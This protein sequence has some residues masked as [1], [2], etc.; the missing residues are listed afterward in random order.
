M[1]NSGFRVVTSLIAQD[2]TN[3]S[4]PTNGQLLKYNSTSGKW[5]NAT[6]IPQ[7]SVVNLTT[8]LAAKLAIASNLSD[9]ASAA[10]ARNNLGLGSIATQASSNVTITGGSITG[11]TDL[12]VADGGTGASDASTARTNLGL[13]TIATQAASA[14][15]I[16]GGTLSALTS[17]TGTTIGGTNIVQA[18][19]AG[20]GNQRMAMNASGLAIATTRAIYFDTG[21]ILSGVYD[22]GLIRSATN[23]VKVTDG[24]SGA[25]NL[26]AATIAATRNTNAVAPLSA[27]ASVSLNAAL[28]NNFTLDVTSGS[29]QNVIQIPTNAVDGQRIVIR[30]KA[31]GSASG[32]ALTLSLAGGAGGFRFGTDLPALTATTINKTDYIGCVYNATDTKWDVVSYTKGF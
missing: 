7:S 25:G 9:L 17:A 16:T 12:A 31:S 1:D 29:T 2:D 19:S 26:T 23:T 28:G 20:A 15:A 14:V 4:S 18:D 3:I 5:E 27:G 11:I 13:G 10:T 21:A 8:D 6:T 32:S 24:S 30:F 22:C